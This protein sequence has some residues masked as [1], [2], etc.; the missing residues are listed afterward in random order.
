[1]AN[2]WLERRVL[3]FA[4][5]GGAKEAPSSTLFAIERAVALG[6]TVIELDVHRSRDGELV[7]CHDPTLERTTDGSGTIS[8]A[9]RDELAGLDAAYWF[10][11]GLGVSPGH[12]P[13]EYPFRGRAPAEHRF[14][15]ASL[16][17]A[18]EACRGVF[19]N[20]DIKEG[21]PEVPAYE[22]ELAL[23]LRRHRREDEVIVASFSDHRTEAF[24]AY[25]P[26]IATS[27]GVSLLT[28][29]V[30]AVR[31]GAPPPEAVR[32]HAALQVPDTVAGVHLVDERLVEATHAFGLAL[33]VFTVD[34][35]AEMARLL[36]IGVD[37]VMTDLPSTLVAL[38][39]RRGMAYRA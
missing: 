27:P 18:L 9:D 28:G 17:E 24:S 3:A 13:E 36:D 20:L 26:E 16:D 21:P 35:E 12:E 37:G 25:A 15:V 33:H 14:G 8:G 4:H 7:V 19:V 30:Q 38:L 34:D 10:V 6:A 29:F 2:P 23:A 1:V 5:Q 32:A 39:E 11:P 22:S 31:A